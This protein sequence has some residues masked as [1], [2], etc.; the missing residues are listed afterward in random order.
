M[1]D[2]LKE[3]VEA[4]SNFLKD[5]GMCIEVLSDKS[6]SVRVEGAGFYVV[7]NDVMNEV[8]YDSMN[9]FHS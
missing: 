7:N 9:A 6:L 5:N 8:Q 2:E 4:L 3:K 1:V